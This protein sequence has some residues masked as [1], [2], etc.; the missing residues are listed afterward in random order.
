M[1]DPESHKPLGRTVAN[2]VINGAISYK[3]TKLVKNLM[4]DYTRF[5]KDDL[6]VNL[7]SGA[8]SLVV[9]GMLEPVTAKAVDVTFDFAGAQ[10]KKFKDRK[11]DDNTE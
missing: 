2:F 9:C 4:T 1:S 6:V 10:Y 8:V 3:S 7:T 5:E 11:K